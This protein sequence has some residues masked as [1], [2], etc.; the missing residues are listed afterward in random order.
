MLT[1][2]AHDFCRA[3]GIIGQLY[4]QVK[5][6]VIP[7][8]GSWRLVAGELGILERACEQM[9]LGTTLAQ[10]QR[11]KPI[12][13]DGSDGVVFADL[14]REIMEIHTRMI[15]ELRSKKFLYIG[16][17]EHF[18]SEPLRDWQPVVELLPQVNDDVEEANKCFAL[19]R[20]GASV[21]HLMRISEAAALELGK[22]VDPTDHK[23][24]FSS[25]LKKI[26][27]L[28]QKT[29]WQDWPVE[30][31]SHKPLFVDALPRLYAVKDSWRDKFTHFDIH[32]VPTTPTWT[33]ERA[34]D[35]Y[36][37]TLSL[38]NMLAERLP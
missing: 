24:Q 37:C 8:S 33:R 35:V 15:D 7:T 6:N 20:Y 11:I 18:F 32:I 5:A 30:A 13:I 1:F 23:P 25:V 36:N 26:D 22:I 9:G 19:E 21:F 12:F 34:L 16:V 14:A 29:K 28:V 3:S 2:Y 31:Q 4:A 10:V 27:N 38:M 17:D